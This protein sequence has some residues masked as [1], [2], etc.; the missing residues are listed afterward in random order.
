MNKIWHIWTDARESFL[1][2]VV[3]NLKTDDSLTILS[4]EESYF[5]AS[6]LIDKTIPLDNDRWPDSFGNYLEFYKNLKKIKNVDIILGS[7]DPMVI[8]EY[9]TLGT[10]HLW[11]N[12]CLYRS[13]AY[14][15]LAKAHET[16]F[17]PKKL[18]L[19]LN[20]KAHYHRCLLIDLLVGNDLYNEGIISWHGHPT[21]WK[22]QHYQWK[23]WNPH[24][25]TVDKG[26]VVD[27]SRL[28]T[29]HCLPKELNDVFLMLIPE[30]YVDQFL[31]TEKTWHA[32][33]AE[34]PFI[35]LG[36]TD[37]HKNLEAMG[38]ELYND[39]IDYSFD[40]EIDLEKRVLMI[41]N[42]LQRLNNLN[43]VNLHETILPKLQ[44]NKIRALQ[45]V[46]R[47]EGVPELA[48][49]FECYQG[50]IKKSKN[51]G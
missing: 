15:N 1:E 23:H 6:T 49:T 22:D 27:Q 7:G 50:I 21:S 10:I 12:F 51:Y 42:E 39:V 38:F 29:Q 19:S 28:T 4:A 17:N 20:T 24:T 11:S 30:T 26:Y 47:E 5:P 40:S 44:K 18:F 35:V 31:V 9:R 36:S 32:I 3:K 37:F 16:N 46:N 33:L 14:L 25:V 34:K 43:F 48:K 2:S 45:M 8:N 13:C 41:I